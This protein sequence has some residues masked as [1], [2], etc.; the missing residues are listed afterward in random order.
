MS[1]DRYREPAAA[2]PPGHTLA[3]VLLVRNLLATALFGLGLL[4]FNPLG[5]PLVLL[6]VGMMALHLRLFKAQVTASTAG[7]IWVLTLMVELGLA[8]LAAHLLLDFGRPWE[9]LAEGQSTWGKAVIVIE[10]ALGHFYY[11]PLLLA[12][13]FVLWRLYRI[14]IPAD[15]PADRP[16]QLFGWPRQ[17]AHALLV[18]HVCT[19]VLGLG[20]NT[21]LIIVLGLRLHALTQGPVGWR[22]ARRSLAAVLLLNLVSALLPLLFAVVVW[23]DLDAPA[24][25]LLLIIWT[26]GKTS[27]WLYAALLAN[28]GGASWLLRWLLRHR[29]AKA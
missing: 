17:V 12:W 19:A 26:G 11:L 15:P 9:D 4:A 5:L 7:L 27:F 1:L 10:H 13:P 21:V 29:S 24:P 8:W 22:W 16:V 18:S 6:G 23:A 25:A 20:L 28:L 2:T 14:L 3:A